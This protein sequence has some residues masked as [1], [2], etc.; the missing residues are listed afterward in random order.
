M[1]SSAPIIVLVVMSVVISTI[2]HKFLTLKDSAYFIPACFIVGIITSIIFQIV[3]YIVLGYLD[4]FFIIALI[5]GA[6]IA[7]AIA[8]GVGLVFRSFIKENKKT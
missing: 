3:G 8:F 6:L 7:S 1:N 4:P 5:M 2:V